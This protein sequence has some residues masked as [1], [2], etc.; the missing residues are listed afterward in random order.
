MS[1]HST[2]LVSAFSSD[3][4]CRAYIKDICSIVIRRYGYL[5][6]R[7]KGERFPACQSHNLACRSSDI[8]LYEAGA[9]GC[10]ELSE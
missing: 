1:H 5:R 3:I 6:R 2:K 10:W 7:E 8:C 4:A 9:V